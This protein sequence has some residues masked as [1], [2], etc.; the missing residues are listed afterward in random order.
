MLNLII[1]VM[2]FFYGVHDYFIIQHFV[3]QVYFAQAAWLR[4][5][6]GTAPASFQKATQFEMSS[7]RFDTEPTEVPYAVTVVG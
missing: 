6:N 1:H 3:V 4:Y 5:C 7:L 2:M